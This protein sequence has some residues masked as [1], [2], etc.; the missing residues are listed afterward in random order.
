MNVNNIGVGRILILGAG[1]WG[2]GGT[3]CKNI[4]GEGGGKGPQIFLLA[5]N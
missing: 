3:Q 1:G 4:L 5:L 2:D